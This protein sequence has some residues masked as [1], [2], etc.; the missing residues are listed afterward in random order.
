[1]IKTVTVKAMQQID[2]AAVQ[3]Y[4][5]PALILME[6]AAIAS[7]FCVLKMLKNKQRKVLV[8]CGQGNNG[9][10]GFACARHLI[11]R[12]LEAQVYFSGEAGKLPAAAKTN[13]NILKRQEIKAFRPDLSVLKRELKNCD[14]VVDALLGIG[15]NKIVREPLYS[16]IK[17]I[18]DSQRPVLSLDVPSGLEASTGKIYGIAVRAKRTVT[19][20]LL[21][22]G[23]LGPG[24]R[25]YTGRIIVADISLPRKLLLH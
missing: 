9:G 2:R 12:G 18:N 23:L 20:G 22:R 21:K 4:G 16:L 5:I 24:A 6:N 17:V 11:N 8:F 25:R 1:M 14:L 13:Y 10:D 7:A 3:R 19:F 15:I